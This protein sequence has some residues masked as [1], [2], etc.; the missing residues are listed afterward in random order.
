MGATLL[1]GIDA[2]KMK[3]YPDLSMRKFDRII[4]NFPHA[5]FKWN[6][7]EMRQIKLHRQLIRGFFN[8]ASHMLRPD[9]EIHI[10][11][12]KG[13]PYSNWNLK[14]IAE[15]NSLVLLECVDFK[16]EE[17]P[18]YE[19][20]IGDGSNCDKPFFLG[21][22][23]TFKFAIGH[24]HKKPMVMQSNQDF[25][26]NEVVRHHR[27]IPFIGTTEVFPL[28]RARPLIGRTEV[29]PH[30]HARSLIERSEFVSH[31]LARPFHG[32]SDVVPHP[33]ARSFIKATEVAFPHPFARPLGGS[34]EVIPHPWPGSFTEMAEIVS[35]PHAR[36]SIGMSDIVPRLNDILHTGFISRSA[37]CHREMGIDSGLFKDY[38]SESSHATFGR[39]VDRD[40]YRSAEGSL[41]NAFTPYMDVNPRMNFHDYIQNL[42]ERHRLS[43]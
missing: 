17:Y 26:W 30:F 43:F 24:A 14:K 23:G 16:S 13:I 9:G 41:R 37:Y 33:F 29:H 15:E 19:N 1:H 18:S 36:P 35:H 22:C 5:G 21:E 39:T 7:K 27:E 28:P 11:H 38:L 4:F 10:N 6:E 31:P 32:S 12:K 34:T 40:L 25:K 2:T 20:K 3:H 8:N 42:E